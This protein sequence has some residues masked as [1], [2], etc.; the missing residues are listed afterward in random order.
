MDSDLHSKI[1]LLI[2]VD[3]ADFRDQAVL[4]SRRVGFSVEQAEDGEGALNILRQRTFDVVV[5]DI[6]RSGLSGVTVLKEIMKNEMPPKVI[7]LTGLAHESR[8]VF[9]RCHAC[10]TNLAYDVREMPDSVELIDKVQNALDHLN[11]LLD[12]VW[13]YSAPVVFERTPTN[14][15]S[16]VQEMWQQIATAHQEFEGIVFMQ[17]QSEDFP[18]K[19]S[20]DRLRIGQV[21]WNLLENAAAA[22]ETPNGVIQVELY[23]ETQSSLPIRVRIADDGD[24]ISPAFAREIFEP[25]ITTKTEGMGL[26]LAMFKR[27][28]EAHDGMVIFTNA[29]G[30]GLNLL[31][32]YPNYPWGNKTDCGL[33]AWRVCSIS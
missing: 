21:I 31:W 9:Q 19:V 1:E 4:Y 2:V 22:C 29:M 15:E 33:K 32:H 17:S 6:H 24:G 11:G 25:F 30:G 14:I 20:I 10:L 5:L 8:N 16:L 13:D 27:I 3:E 18:E 28:V 26:G 7:M 12:E 23:C